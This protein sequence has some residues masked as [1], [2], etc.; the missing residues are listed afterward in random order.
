MA[1]AVQV[2]NP[3]M[4]DTEVSISLP[5]NTQCIDQ[6]FYVATR[7]YLV[8]GIS[9]VH[10][11]A[12][13]DAGAVNLQVSKDSGTAAPGTGTDLL[14]N[15]SNAGFNCKATANT[16][17]TGTL[18]SGNAT[19]TLAAGDRLALDFAGTTTALAGVTVTVS[20]RRV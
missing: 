15:N 1:I 20:L 11:T 12:G 14:T 4:L 18:V 16:V 9:Y 2:L 5:L 13:S 8:T 7:P 17:Q 19:L 3:S 6:V 10:A